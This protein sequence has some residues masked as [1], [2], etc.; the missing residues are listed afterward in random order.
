MLQCT[1]VT[2]E[3]TI[4][5]QPS[6][7]VALTLFDGEI[8]IAPGHTPMIGRLGCGE[9]RIH[10]EEGMDRYYV[11]GGFV[12][13]LNNVVSVLT[14][15][16]VPAAEIEEEVAEERLSSARS[17][18]RPPRRPQRLAIGRSSKVA[19][20]CASPAEHARREDLAAAAPAK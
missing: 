14:H 4:F 9:M 11:E 5:D 1:V 15:R 8:G 17:A 12:E 13:V 2:P 19:A 6:D 18:R 10:H 16:A 20:S 3:R 7:F